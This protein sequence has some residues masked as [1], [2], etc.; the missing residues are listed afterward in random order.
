[1]DVTSHKKTKSAKMRMVSAAGRYSR[2]NVLLSQF[3][4]IQALRSY[5]KPAS[6][7]RLQH[8]TAKRY[9][10]SVEDIKKNEIKEIKSSRP[11]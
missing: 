4:S 8:G 10:V 1:M 3:S 7:D 11:L 6:C 2:A 9:T 5:T